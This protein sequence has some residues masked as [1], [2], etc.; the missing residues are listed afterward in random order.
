MMKVMVD[1]T[2]CKCQII[3][4]KKNELHQGAVPNNDGFEPLCFPK[5]R[6]KIC[7]P[8]HMFTPV[9]L[10]GRSFMTSSTVL[11]RNHHHM[12]ASSHIVVMHDI[13]TFFIFAIVVP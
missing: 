13:A 4:H 3:K 6:V 10:E 11:M 2:W 8:I 12:G 5:I 1:P 9:G 7:P